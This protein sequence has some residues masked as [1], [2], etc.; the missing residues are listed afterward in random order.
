MAF[1]PDDNTFLLPGPV[2]IHPRVLRAL[3]R[4]AMAHRDP[5]FVDIN[6]RMNER[7]QEVFQTASPVV[8][9]AGSGTAGME[10]AAV[11]LLRK[12]DAVVSLDGGKFGNRFAQLAGHYGDSTVVSAEWGQPFDLDVVA[13]T[14]ARVKPKL[15][16]LTHNETSTTVTNDLRRVCEIAHEH[17]AL[18]AADC[19]TSI[20]G[21][22]VPVDGWGVDLAVTGSQKALGM[23][24]GL[25]FVS[26]SEAAKA[27]MYADGGYYLNLLKY[28]KKN[29]DNDTPFTPAIPLHVA[30]V[31]AL[32]I[33]HEEGL[34]NRFAKVRR[35][36]N[37]VRSAIEA[38]GL[39]FMV[40]ASHRSDTVTAIKYPDGVADKDV[41]GVLKNKHNVIIAGAQDAWKGKVFRIGHMGTVSFAELAGGLTLLEKVLL[42]AGAPIKKG[43]WAEAFSA[44]VP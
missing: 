38:M 31:E 33:I 25:A 34:E 16:T 13:E 23:P 37:A 26:V 43:V 4:P 30:A 42:E 28:V 32:D 2:K 19:I 6:R 40:P 10:A 22:P 39:E 20:A 21:I 3:S 12:S 29:A 14:V 41:R 27:A 17:G 7:L 36:A 44:H 9:I 15:V 18:V 5:G 11:S 1:D 35:Q 24:S 8:T